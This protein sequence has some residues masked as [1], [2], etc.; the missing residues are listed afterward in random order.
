MYN[1][2][3]VVCYYFEYRASLGFQFIFHIL[4]THKLLNFHEREF[5]MM[6]NDMSLKLLLSFVSTTLSDS[7]LKI[8]K[9][10]IIILFES[11]VYTN[12]MTF[13]TIGLLLRTKYYTLYVSS[14]T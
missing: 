3:H 6:I 7:V 9:E 5:I 1:N 14:I 13:M 4:P 8:I 2:N 11:L 12:M 10:G